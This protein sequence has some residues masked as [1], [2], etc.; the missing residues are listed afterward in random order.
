[1]LDYCAGKRGE[2]EERRLQ[3]DGKEGAGRWGRR[4]KEMGKKVKGNGEEGA[5]R[6][7]RR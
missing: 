1:M 6:W 5:G 3:G 2:G 7:G 4:C